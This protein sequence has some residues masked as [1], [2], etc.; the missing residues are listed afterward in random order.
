MNKALSELFSIIQNDD[1]NYNESLSK[2]DEF[3][4]SGDTSGVQDMLSNQLLSV[5]DQ[6]ERYQTELNKIYSKV[7]SL[8][9]QINRISNKRGYKNNINS[10]ST[11]KSPRVPLSIKR[12]TF[13]P[14]VFSPRQS[15]S[16]IHSANF[17]SSF[18][19]D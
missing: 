4:L 3:I 12:Y 7:G 2:I 15:P 9:S 18:G 5:L 8:N 19:L 14:K 16:F 1:D 13:S 11:P 10:P 6:L 17:N